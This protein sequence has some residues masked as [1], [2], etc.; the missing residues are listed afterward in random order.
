MLVGMFAIEDRP[1]G[2]GESF[3]TRLTLVALYP[4][5]VLP[6]FLRFG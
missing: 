1:D 5:G 2:F 3:A 4:A 6:I